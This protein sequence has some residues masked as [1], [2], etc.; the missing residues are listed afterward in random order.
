MSTGSRNKASNLYKSQGT[1]GGLSQQ[2]INSLG[3]NIK[4]KMQLF[5]SDLSQDPYHTEFIVTR[6]GNRQLYNDKLDPAEI[7]YGYP[8]FGYNMEFDYNIPEEEF[9]GSG[10]RKFMQAISPNPKNERIKNY[11]E[12]VNHKKIMR[13]IELTTGKKHNSKQMMDQLQQ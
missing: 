12:F 6:T 4:R 9:E 2:Y 13:L 3:N 8:D 7:G 10:W 5:Q 1:V 11:I